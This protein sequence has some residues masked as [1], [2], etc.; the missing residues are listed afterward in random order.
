MSDISSVV[1]GFS[2]GA[3]GL[4]IPAP[5]V[6]NGHA[7]APANRVFATQDGIVK[8]SRVVEVSPPVSGPLQADRV[9]LSDV[10]R[11]L[12]AIRQFPEVRLDRVATVRQQIADGIYDTDERLDQALDRFLEDELP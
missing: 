6:L 12:D 2:G 7:A 9:E 11:Y 10:A 3:N 5:G 8:P 1:P 4:G